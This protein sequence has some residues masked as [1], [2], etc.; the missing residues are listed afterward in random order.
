VRVIYG[1]VYQYSRY[2]RRA[3]VFAGGSDYLI[4]IAAAADNGRSGRCGR[5]YFA[6]LVL[7]EF[8]GGAGFGG[9]SG[10][11]ASEILAGHASSET[12]QG[13]R[14]FLTFLVP[15]RVAN[16]TVYFRAAQGGQTTIR[17]R[18]IGNVVSV[19]LPISSLRETFRVR[20]MW[21]SASG[22]TIKPIR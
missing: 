16:V 3:R 19:I 14:T 13:G 22:Q 1:S 2:V 20:S 5:P 9:G 17:T 7:Y 8:R 11:T 18:P 4:P 6:G 10:Y 15:D 21:Y 12:G